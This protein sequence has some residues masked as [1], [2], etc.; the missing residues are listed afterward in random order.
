MISPVS[1]LAWG[2]NE[3]AFY[4]Y[5]EYN[6]KKNMCIETYSILFY[7]H[8]N[9]DIALRNAAYNSDNPSEYFREWIHKK[10]D[11]PI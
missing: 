3:K 4:S 9:N 2:N 10:L 8:I 7:Y 1:N 5:I 11:I 6:Y